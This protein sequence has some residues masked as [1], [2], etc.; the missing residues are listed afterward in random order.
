MKTWQKVKMATVKSGK[1][2]TYLA[3]LCPKCD[4]EVIVKTNY[5]P[6]CGKRLRRGK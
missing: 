5:C 1:V 4:N 6:N 3:Y 2:I